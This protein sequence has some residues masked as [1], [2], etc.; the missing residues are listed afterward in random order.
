[1]F[2]SNTWTTSNQ[3]MNENIWLVFWAKILDCEAYEMKFGMNHV[4]STGSMAW[5]VDLQS[6]MLLLCYS[7]LLDKQLTFPGFVLWLTHCPTCDFHPMIQLLSQAW[8]L[9]TAPFSNVHL[10]MHAPSSITTSG[11]IVTLGPIRQLAPI[12]ALGSCEKR[13]GE[14]LMLKLILWRM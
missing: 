13:T 8:D 5:P 3:W 4:P 12:L 11:P 2:K 6:S 10:L 7:C 14:I 1:M 9:I